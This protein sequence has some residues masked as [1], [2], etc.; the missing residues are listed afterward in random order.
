MLYILSQQGGQ[1]LGSSIN[2]YHQDLITLKFPLISFLV[3]KP[4]NTKTGSSFSDT[5]FV[6]VVCQI[7][8]PKELQTTKPKNLEH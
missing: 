3:N 7:T 8:E 1:N 4:W 5:C 2:K 6:F